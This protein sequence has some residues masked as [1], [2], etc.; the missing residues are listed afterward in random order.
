MVTQGKAKENPKDKKKMKKKVSA[1][2]YTANRKVVSK[3]E[4]DSKGCVHVRARPGRATD[5]HSIAERVKREK[6][7]ERTRYL[8]SL[9]PG[10]DKTLGNAEAIEQIISYVL[11]L[12]QQVQFLNMKIAELNPNPDYSVDDFLADEALT[13][14]RQNNPCMTMP[15]SEVVNSGYDHLNPIQQAVPGTGTEFISSSQVAGTTDNL[16]W[17]PGPPFNEQWSNSL[18]V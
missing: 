18:G 10:L 16:S 14:L 15:T 6:I 7:R 9:V 17:M 1:E 8:E 2:A 13:E 12:Q 4:E 11:S 3:Y 5:I